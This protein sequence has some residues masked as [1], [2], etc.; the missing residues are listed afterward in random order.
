MRKNVNMTFMKPKYRTFTQNKFAKIVD[1]K[2]SLITGALLTKSTAKK[3]T[4]FQVLAGLLQWFRPFQLLIFW[5][6]FMH[7]V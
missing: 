5:F 7:R 4:L 6:I 2:S 1:L 3:L